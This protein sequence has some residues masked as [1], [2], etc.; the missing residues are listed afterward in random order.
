MKRKVIQIAGSTQLVSLPR[1]W[2]LA[3][4]VKKGDEVEVEA[5]GSQ[6]II[7][8]E[9]KSDIKSITIKLPTSEHFLKRTITSLYIHGYD[10]IVAE[11]DD[12]KIMPRIQQVI[13]GCLGYEIVSQTSSNCTIKSIVSASSEEFNVMF[14]KAMI[15]LV[16]MA[17]DSHSA[18]QSK[19]Y[20]QLTEIALREKSNN[21][22]TLFCLRLLNKYGYKEHAKLT[23]MYTI[24]CLVE[25]AVDCY[26][27]LYKH[28]LEHKPN[29]SRQFMQAYG[30][31]IMLTE[32]FYEIFFKYDASKALEF[33]NK[34]KKTRDAGF[35][36]LKSKRWHESILLYYMLQILDR[37]HHALVYVA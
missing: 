20:N 35:K 12:P 27:D 36:M 14:R 32:N 16:E 7:S 4:N 26:R 34:V 21:K 31:V 22:I 8:T 33:K 17:K 23:T 3:H 29:L 11:F 25:N 19:D 24:V 13:D 1:N 6:V 30:D 9:T 28:I 37:F 5:Q 15:M 2:A 18:I 10:E